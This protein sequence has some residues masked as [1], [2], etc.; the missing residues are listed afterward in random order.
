MTNGFT[1]P[2]ALSLI[3]L[4]VSISVAV[5]T[6]V[7]SRRTVKHTEMADLQEMR[8][9]EMGSLR[10]EIA[11][12][13]AEIARLHVELAACEQRCKDEARRSMDLMDRL[14]RQDRRSGPA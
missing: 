1:L 8:N 5:L 3:G 7:M 13:R 9:Q 10:A 12:L 6:F 4:F 2:T 14:Y 11:S